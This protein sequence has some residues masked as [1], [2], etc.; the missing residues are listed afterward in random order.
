M[1]AKVKDSHDKP[2]RGRPAG[3]DARKTRS[4]IIAAAAKCF[5]S[6]EYSETSIEQIAAEAGLTGPA[7]YAHFKSKDDL[8]IK[9]AKAFIQRGHRIMS[10][11]ASQPGSWDERLARVIDA[12]RAVQEEVQTFPLIYSVVQARMVRFPERYSEVIKLRQEYSEIFTSIAQ[13]AIDER[14]L[15][16]TADAQITGELLMAFTSNS[17]GI[18]RHYHNEDGDLDKILHAVKALLAIQS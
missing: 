13:Q 5:N 18:V 6:R 3:G 7:I 15:P 17:I 12:Q 2:K 10:E 4:R 16:K 8:F 1:T 9:T 11:A 14:A